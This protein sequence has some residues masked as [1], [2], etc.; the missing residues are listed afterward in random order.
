LYEHARGHSRAWHDEYD[1]L[2]S[3]LGE[4]AAKQV[5]SEAA[6]ELVLEFKMKYMSTDVD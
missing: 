3:V 6:R 2:F 4:A 1:K 5:A